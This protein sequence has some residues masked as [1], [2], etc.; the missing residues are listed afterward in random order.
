MRRRRDENLRNS[1]QNSHTRSLR[2]VPPLAGL[3]VGMTLHYYFQ[4]ALRA[5]GAL[6][7]LTTVIPTR[8]ESASEAEGP[9]PTLDFPLPSSRPHAYTG[10][11]SHRAMNRAAPVL[12]SVLLGAFSVGVAVVPFYVL[13]NRD[14]NAL[15]TNLESAKA[16]AAAAESEKQQIADEANAKVDAANAE[17]EKAQTMIAAIKEEQSLRATAKKLVKPGS[18]ELLAWTAVV[19]IPQHASILIPKTSSVETDDGNALRITT[20]PTSSDPYAR[21]DL[22]F[23]ILPYESL[24]EQ[25]FLAGMASGTDVAY[26][27]ND[28]QLLIGKKGISYA[29]GST[30]YVLEFRGGGEKKS[31][32]YL[33]EI[34]SLGRNGAER[35]LSTLA[36]E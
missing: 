24:N 9:Y 11:D 20:S 33:K 35:V 14:R 26:V 2:L 18:R 19:S 8:S 6:F 23:E 4:A 1:L 32:V 36:F 16:R 30:I 17:V 34:P 22:W 15:S 21:G 12:L 3:S 13:A 27:I 25:Q 7:S 31:L 28:D 10:I 5:E 29:D